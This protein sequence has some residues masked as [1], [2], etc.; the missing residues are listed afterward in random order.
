VATFY[1]QYKR[2]PNGDYTVGVC[3]NTL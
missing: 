3:T 2:H 1:T